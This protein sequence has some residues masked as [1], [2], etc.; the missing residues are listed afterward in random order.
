M[1][2]R[3]QSDK[4]PRLGWFLLILVLVILLY[5]PAARSDAPAFEEVTISPA[6]LQDWQETSFAGRTDYRVE[7]GGRG[8]ALHATANGSAS[9]L[10][11][12]VQ[13][14]L[15]SL[16][17]L[18][19]HW[20]LERAPSRTDERA[21]AG[22][23]QGLRLTFLHQGG[24]GGDSILALQYVWSQTE[25][26]NARWA[27]AFVANARQVA[28]RSGPAQPGSWQA[29]RRDLRSDFRVAFG[30]DVD[31]VDAICLMT[32]GDQTGA[33]VEGWYG[34]ITFQAR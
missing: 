21:K 17:V 3:Q 4:L 19:W 32:D 34:D 13:I 14:D 9:G 6:E 10:C 28:V 11:R 33:L 8:P 26:A 16:P 31:R 12:E 27:N 24:T 20:R 30:G 5:E 25:P 15:R 22:D 1:R 18:R 29:E 2:V 7:E 23:D